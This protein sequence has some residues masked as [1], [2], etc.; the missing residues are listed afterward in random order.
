MAATE[1]IYLTHHSLGAA[2]ACCW[3]MTAWTAMVLQDNEEVWGQ[4]KRL[5][6]H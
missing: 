4:Q 1:A 6:V 5:G 2:R 3:Q